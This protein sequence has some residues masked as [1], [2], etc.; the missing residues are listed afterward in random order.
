M[1]VREQSSIRYSPRVWGLVDWS[2]SLVILVIVVVSIIHLIATNWWLCW[3]TGCRCSKSKVTAYWSWFGRFLIRWWEDLWVVESH[4]NEH[5]CLHGHC[6]EGHCHCH[7]SAGVV[8]LV[9]IGGSG[10]M[11]SNG[12]TKVSISAVNEMLNAMISH[13]ICARST[14]WW[15]SWCKPASLSLAVGFPMLN[16]MRRSVLVL[17]DWRKQS[18]S[19]QFSQNF[20]TMVFQVVGGGSKC[21]ALVEA[22]SAAA[23]AIMLDNETIGFPT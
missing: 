6:G 10:W 22:V 21:G 23:R 8:V 5:H 11:F 15:L 14:G 16:H 4:D 19:C 9:T 1:H 13:Q 18:A 17:V 7:P 12:C 20:L 3:S 2:M